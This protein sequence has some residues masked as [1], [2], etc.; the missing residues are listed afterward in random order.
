V[1]AV[2]FLVTAW[3]ERGE[4]TGLIRSARRGFPT[5]RGRNTMVLIGIDPHKA[6]HTAV[7][8]DS[9]ETALGQLTVKAD[10]HQIECLLN[11]AIDYPD[12]RWAIESAN[13]LGFS[14]AQQL[15][16][17]GE[18]VVDVPPTLAARVR[19]L[20]PRSDGDNRSRSG[21]PVT[22]QSRDEAARW[23]VLPTTEPEAAI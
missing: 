23:L 7:A 10:C 17:A 8:V 21:D 14:L 20:G 19:V 22:S 1:S 3:L 6:T 11:W 12:R 18:D 13:G 9:E 16:A 15:V 2:E 4:L 5:H